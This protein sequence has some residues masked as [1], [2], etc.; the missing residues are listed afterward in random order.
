[1][2]CDKFSDPL[3]YNSFLGGALAACASPRPRTPIPAPVLVAV[4]PSLGVGS[5]KPLCGKAA[6][7]NNNAALRAAVP[8]PCARAR[9]ALRRGCRPELARAG[10]GSGGRHSGTDAVRPSQRS[11][12]TAFPRAAP[13]RSHVGLQPRAHRV[14]GGED[15]LRGVRAAPRGAQ[16]PREGESAPFGRPTALMTAPGGVGTLH[17]ACGGAHGLC[18]CGGV[19]ANYLC[20][21]SSRRSR[22]GVPDAEWLHRSVMLCSTARPAG[23]WCLGSRQGAAL[24]INSSTFCCY[25]SPTSI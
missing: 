6:D 11:P 5:L 12:L 2:F 17:R 22:R 23:V 25:S 9:P 16:E 7:K 24:G 4:A 14:P 15:L 19:I 20:A 18:C 21:Q 1:M 13:C 3:W 8:A 10:A